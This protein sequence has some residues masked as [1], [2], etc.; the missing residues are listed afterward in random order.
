MNN[1]V[2]NSLASCEGASVQLNNSAA[3]VNEIAGK[4]VNSVLELTKAIE[5]FKVRNEEN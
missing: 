2:T 4:A 5:M 3:S 1:E